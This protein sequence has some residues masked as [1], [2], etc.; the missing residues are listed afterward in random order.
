MASFQS[1]SRDSLAKGHIEGCFGPE[2]RCSHR[3]ILRKSH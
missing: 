3:I 2:K 1:Y